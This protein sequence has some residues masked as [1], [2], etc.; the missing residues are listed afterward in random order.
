MARKSVRRPTEDMALAK[1]MRDKGYQSDP[2]LLQ[3]MVLGEDGTRYLVYFFHTTV[4]MSIS[5][6][7]GQWQASWK[8]MK[9]VDFLRCHSIIYDYKKVS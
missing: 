2:T 9:F 7:W 5:Q 1:V 6:L 3:K 8:H 4:N